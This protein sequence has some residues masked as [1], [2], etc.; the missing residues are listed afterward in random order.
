MELPRS[1]SS[2]PSLVLVVLLLGC[3]PAEPPA[4]HTEP[5]QARAEG[6]VATA[7]TS[8]PEPAR[9]W[10]GGP[11]PGRDG[12]FPLEHA[13]RSHGRIAN[14]EASIPLA[15]YTR[16]DGLHN[17]CWACHTESTYPNLR[18][19]AELQ[20]AYAF[21]DFGRDNHWTSAFVDRREAIDAIDD[22]AMLAWVRQDNY[23]PLRELLLGQVTPWA[24]PFDL[25]VHGGFDD[26]GFARDGSHWRAFR[27]KPFVGTFWPTNGS[28]DDVFIRLPAAFREQAGAPSRLIYEAN[29]ALLE[30]SLASD[31]RIADAEV[32]WPTEPLDERALG[33]D[34][35][36][37]SELR[38]ATTWLR[39]L[40]SRYL[41]DAADHPLHRGLYPEG[42]ELL[43]SVRYLDPDAP[44]MTATRIKEL[45]Y[46]HKEHE[47]SRGR[48]F[49]LYQQ[50]AAERDDG[51]LPRFHG[52][53]ET[54]LLGP[55]G[56]R[57]QGYIEDAEGRLRLQTDEEHQACM[58]CHTGLGV[59]A[60]GT[61]SFARKVPGAAGWGYQSLAGIPDVPQ[62]RHRE[63]EV[64]TYLRRAGG[65]DELRANDEMLARFFPG[66]V[67]DEAELRRAAPGGDRILADLV[68]P[69]R[70]RALALDKAYLVLVREQGFERGRD[71]LLAPP[72]NVHRRIDDEST[73]LREA[74]RVYG[75]GTL[76]LDWSGTAAWP[77]TPA[78]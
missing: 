4:D 9:P 52:D 43:H 16:T 46:L 18:E 77:P 1:S 76:R 6:S 63:P 55:F 14:R 11:G 51:A 67:L 45:R 10:R 68:M 56:W 48:I 7:T 50:E 34:L 27:Y 32:R 26:E 60:D 30:A 25:D 74:G 3:R 33:V 17:P 71:A 78:S 72:S 59:T 5:A 49:A 35:D 36:G 13:R 21:S 53:A 40:P 12:Y 70:S 22:D 41:G 58:G 64:L 19:D 47:Q 39:G 69:S 8:T 44:G 42:T 54:G 28:T 2:S 75:D 73:G 23:A 37:D 31:P 15:C 20:E 29:L 65:G 24:Y 38:P 61:F 57:V 66:G 62:L